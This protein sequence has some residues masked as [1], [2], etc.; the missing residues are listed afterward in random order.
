[1]NRGLINLFPP[2]LIF[3]GHPTTHG[4]F[5]GVSFGMDNGISKSCSCF[6]LLFDVTE[7]IPFHSLPIQPVLIDDMLD[8]NAP[9]FLPIPV[10]LNQAVIFCLTLT[11]LQRIVQP[12]SAEPAAS[13]PLADLFVRHHCREL[14][15]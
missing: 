9:H 15:A 11:L 7:L 12:D 4:S 3:F 14:V 5:F 6:V 1:M 8:N 13:T 10:L 2:H